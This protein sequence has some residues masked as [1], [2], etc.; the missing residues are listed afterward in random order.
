MQ[1]YLGF[2]L[3]T[4]LLLCSAGYGCVGGPPSK[5]GGAGGSGTPGAGS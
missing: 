3:A 1:R 2:A 5:G 4:I